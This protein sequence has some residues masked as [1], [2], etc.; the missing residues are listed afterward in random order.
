VRFVT[1]TQLYALLSAA[2]PE[3]R[4]AAKYYV[5]GIVDGLSLLRDPTLCVDAS[6]DSEDLLDL[7][8][9]TLR[10]RPEIRRYNAASLVREI[11]SQGHPCT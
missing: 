7:L 4:G 5:L 8:E 1:G 11:L 9:S 3:Q 10:E 6:T 2:E